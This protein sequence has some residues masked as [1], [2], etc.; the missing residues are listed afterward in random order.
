MA[1]G[2]NRA[3]IGIYGNNVT[4]A[5]ATLQL[6]LW[7]QEQD[8]SQEYIAIARPDSGI[9]L[10]TAGLQ[11]FAVNRKARFSYLK[12]QTDKGKLNHYDV[13]KK[14]LHESFYQDRL[15][16]DIRANMFR[17][18]HQLNPSATLF[19][20]DYHIE[21]GSDVRSTLEL[22]ARQ[23]LDI[24]EQGAQ[25]GG[26]GVQGH[27]EVPVGTIVSS[28]FDKLATLGIPI[29]LTE[30]DVSSV[31]EFIRAYD[32]EVMLREAFAHHAV[33]G[34]VLW[35]FWE[36]YMSRKN[37]YFV[38][39]SGK[40][41]QAGKRFLSLKKEWMF[42]A[43]GSMNGKGEFRFR[44]FHGTY[45]VEIVSSSQTINKTF[46]VDKGNSPL[47]IVAINT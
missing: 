1:D 41:N 39:A 23:V 38:D 44:G 3:S 6:T 33:E 43:N 2:K 9:D 32:L 21:D 30:L 26:I 4:A 27:I 47:V 17:T 24:R 19:V 12:K 13:H 10:M 46:V 5:A 34:V 11:I 36:L 15:G 25:V 20:N 28:A 7:V 42:E 18:A 37:A 40:I 45:E 14:M 29:W 16:Y 31:N 35:G 22:Y 8:L